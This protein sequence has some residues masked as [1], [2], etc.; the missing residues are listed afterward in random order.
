[1]WLMQVVLW[2]IYSS[3]FSFQE[4]LKSGRPLLL[5]AGHPEHFVNTIEAEACRELNEAQ[6]PLYI[7]IENV[8]AIRRD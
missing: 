8:Y 4:F 1:M 2:R 3:R 7:L 6:T 5:G